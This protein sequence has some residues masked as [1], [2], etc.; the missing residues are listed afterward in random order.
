MT[1]GTRR[2][3]PLIVCLALGAC[4]AADRGAPP[5]E[6]RARL[7]PPFDL[8]KP[9]G[10]KGRR[11]REEA[12][13]GAPPP[14]VRDLT[15][16]GFYARGSGSSVIDPAAMRRYRAARAPVRSFQRALL[17]RTDRYVETRRPR[18][19]ACALAWLDR[20]A[21]AG[22]FL[23]RVSRQGGYER[24]W[25]LGAVSMAYLK[26]R[27]ASGLDPAR[28]KAVERW[29][30][31]W[32]RVVHADYADPAKSRLTSRRNNHAYWAAWSVGLAAVVLDDRSLLDWAMTRYRRATRQI[33]P[34]GVLPLEL[35]RGSKALHYH[36]Y[37]AAALVMLD[38]LG[39]RNGYAAGGAALGRLVRLVAAGLSDPAFF[40]RRTGK[41]QNW[42]GR[43][44]GSKLAWMEPR[45][46]RR[47]EPALAPWIRRFRP[48]RS[49]LLGG[50]ATLLYGAP[51]PPHRGAVRG[52]LPP[53][54]RP[55]S[56]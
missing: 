8:P 36:L 56:R 18:T 5:A 54:K 35:A 1:P 7:K 37:A 43:L 34:E 17:A 6:S 13:C 47:R 26:A 10:A 41:R 22:A 3:L 49:R 12:P 4:G 40:V 55:A 25:A 29:I 53:R 23:G 14:P 21:R 31:E 51:L 52:R 9:R 33:T 46:A 48:M 30:G 20:W 39:A 11:G 50:D 16:G 2:A 27:G 42:V 45:Y 24:K 32:A 19:A 38:E 28:K 44:D 15:F